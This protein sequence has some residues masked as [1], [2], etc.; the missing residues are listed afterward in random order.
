MPLLE[1]GFAINH[2][3][4]KESNFA[5][6]MLILYLTRQT[7]NQAMYWYEL[8]I[9]LTLMTVMDSVQCLS[10]CLSET[11]SLSVSVQYMSNSH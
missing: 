7:I 8:I 5:S 9:T 3:W 11:D 1:Y 4:E 6:I 10:V 2:A